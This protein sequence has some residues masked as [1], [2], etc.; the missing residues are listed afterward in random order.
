LEALPS[1]KAVPPSLSDSVGS[2]KASMV[3]SSTASLMLT[4]SCT[5]CPVSANTACE[6]VVAETL[7]GDSIPSSSGALSAA[8]K[9]TAVPWLSVMT[10]PPGL[11]VGISR[12]GVCWPEETV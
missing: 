5:V 7:S 9:S 4:A 2:P 8:E 1:E 10:A 12:F 11:T 6:V 3:S